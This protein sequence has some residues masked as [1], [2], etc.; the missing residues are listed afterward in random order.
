MATELK[1]NG[2]VVNRA[3][4]RISLG[5]WVVFER[6]GMPRLSFRRYAQSL[7]TLPY[8]GEGDEVQLLVDG[9]LRFT[10]DVRA[11]EPVKQAK[12]RWEYR[13]EAEGIRA[14]GDRF[15]VTEEQDG[16]DRIVYNRPRL[17][18][19]WLPGRAGRSVGHIITSALEQ[20]TNKANLIRYGLG[21]LVPGD[22][23]AAHAVLSGYAVG[24]VVVDAGGSGYDPANPPTVL[25]VGGGGSGATAT[26]TVSGGVVTGITVTS[27]GSGYRWPPIVVVSTLP[28]TTL[29]DLA[30]MDLVPP[31]SVTVGGERFLQAVGDFARDWYPN[32]DLHVEPDGT[33]RFLDQRRSAGPEVV[34][35]GDGFGAVVRAVVDPLTG[36]L[37]GAEVIDGGVNY[38]TA[39]ASVVGGGGTGA[40][41]SVTVSGGQVVTASVGTAGSGYYEGSTLTLWHGIQPIE[42]PAIQRNHSD[43]YGRVVVRGHD[44]VLGALLTQGA[45]QLVEKFDHDGLTSAQAKTKYDPR[46]ALTPGQ[47]PGGARATAIMAKAA[48]A[49]VTVTA[50]GSGFTSAPTLKWTGGGGT[51]LT[52]TATV[53]GGKIT[54]VTVNSSSSDFSLPPTI[55]IDNTANGGGWGATFTANLAARAVS[56]IQLDAGGYAYTSAPQVRIKGG[57]GSGATATAALT[58]DAVSSLTLTAG[59]TGYTTVPRVVIGAP[60]GP[61]YDT[62]AVLSVTDFS[63]IVVQSDDD[64]KIWP[65]NHW[66]QTD[67]GRHG[68]LLL[69]ETTGTGIDNHYQT[70][71]IS[72]GGLAAGGS[73]TLT[74]DPPLPHNRFDRY[75]LYGVSGGSSVVYRRYTVN[76]PVASS[77]TNE[78]FTFAA[79]FHD[80]SGNAATLTWFNTAAILWSSTGQPPYMSGPLEF[81]IDPD[82]GTITFARPVYTLFGTP[83]KHRKGELDGVPSDIAVLVGVNQKAL[84]T[85]YPP[86]DAITGDPVFEG[87]AFDLLGLQETLTVT[88]DGWRDKVGTDNMAKLAKEWHDA[89]KDIHVDGVVQ[90]LGSYFPPALAP[91]LA[92]SVRGYNGAEYDTGMESMAIPVTRVE[93]EFSPDGPLPVTVSMQVSN[94]RYHLSAAAFVTTPAQAEPIGIP[95]GVFQ[96]AAMQYGGMVGVQSYRPGEVLDM[97]DSDA[98]G[99]S[100]STRPDRRPGGRGGL[101]GVPGIGGLAG[102]APTP[103][104]AA[105]VAE[106]TREQAKAKAEATAQAEPPPRVLPPPVPPDDEEDA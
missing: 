6:G 61:G 22:G 57:G 93:C 38:T 1:V 46:E 89:V 52:M 26:A 51:T 105:L 91:G 4:S 73:T 40:T 99:A 92:L 64:T 55:Y 106:R 72:N 54:A 32:H 103:S 74:L 67:A 97:R 79:P 53:S 42:A 100:R 31:R 87:S 41:V 56:S 34:V 49:S 95:G 20:A 82:A 60:K 63:N 3:T 83:S 37:T 13:Y 24:S 19:L 5:R 30:R 104:P 50:G 62:G 8:P 65:A 88:V 90:W 80:P 29:N 58:G 12:R 78:Q 21:N 39:S 71:V 98:M 76:D 66:D 33:I 15:P 102:L 70:E 86:D 17:D 7:Q 9:V 101:A 10:G 36:G 85:A 2:S 16:S 77:M 14:R 75:E 96:A 69:T 11:C 43:C 81:E 27:G 18:P 48:V 59:G 68:V 84:T 35:S 28:P 23:G 25:L 44:Y 45:G 94:R 47:G